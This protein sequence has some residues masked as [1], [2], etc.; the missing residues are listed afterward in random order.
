M[1]GRQWDC[2]AAGHFPAPSEN[3]EAGNVEDSPGLYCNYSSKVCSLKWEKDEDYMG[4]QPQ[5]GKA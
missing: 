3:P 1:E 4:L 2:D 5:P